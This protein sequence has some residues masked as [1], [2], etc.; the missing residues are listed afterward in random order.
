[1]FRSSTGCNVT[2]WSESSLFSSQMKR[3]FHLSICSFN[4]VKTFS[5]LSLT[6]YGLHMLRLLFKGFRDVVDGLY[7]SM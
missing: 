7:I 5:S 2:G 6:G 3:S 4:L 1:M